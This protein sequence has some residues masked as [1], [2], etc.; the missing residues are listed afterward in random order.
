MVRGTTTVVEAWSVERL[1]FDTAG[2]QVRFRADLRTAVRALVGSPD[3]SL[4]CAYESA[5]Q[6]LGAA[7]DVL[8]YDVGVSAFTGIEVGGVIFERSIL[9]PLPS[10]VPLAGRAEHYHRYEVTTHR[11][12]AYW[13][14]GP[15][16][17]AFVSAPVPA[18]AT[19]VE[20]AAAVERGDVRAIRSAAPG[21][22]LC[23][24]ATV[25]LPGGN[26]AALYESMKPLLDGLLAALGV[27]D[28]GDRLVAADLRTRAGEALRIRGELFE[29]RSL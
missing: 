1:R 22:W 26:R 8:F 9:A 12:P 16:V 18:P 24:R 14:P 20:V 19:A 27:P 28:P 2:W 5:S 21:S 7:E 3:R 25:T 15:P 23:L 6:D 11:E 10:P 17:A 13:S 29:A 4:A